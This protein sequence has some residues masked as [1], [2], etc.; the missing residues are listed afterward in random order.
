MKTFNPAFYVST[1][2]IIY[3]SSKDPAI[4]KRQFSDYLKAVS[5]LSIPVYVAA[6]NHDTRPGEGRNSFDKLFR[7]GGKTYYYF[8]YNNVYFIVL[9]AYK[10]KYRGAIRG[11]ETDMA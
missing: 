8:D 7:N 5:V 4:L 9:D 6:G 1:G 10:G 3:G 11:D 2:D